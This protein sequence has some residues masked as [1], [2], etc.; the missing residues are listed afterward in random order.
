MGILRWLLFLFVGLPTQLVVM[1]V[2]PIL[3]LIWKIFFK[4]TN[5]PFRPVHEEIEA[6]H[7]KTRNGGMYLDNQDDHGAF[8][9]YGFIGKSGLNT[10]IDHKGNF[11]RRV[12]EDYTMNKQ[13]VSG[14]V[15]VAWVFA[16]MFTKTDTKTIK[17]AV[18]NYLAYLGTRSYDTAGKGHVSNRC[19]NF[20]INYCPDSAV[21]KLG[22]PMAGP[23]FYTTSALLARAYHIGPFYKLAFW[24]HWIILGGWYWALAPM[25]FTPNKPLYYVR[26]ITMKALYIHL[27]VFGPKWWI[28]KPMKFITFD[29]ATSENDLFRAMLGIEPGHLPMSMDA[30][31]SQ[32]ADSTSRLTEDMNFQIPSIIRLIARTSRAKEAKK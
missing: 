3:Y 28:I 25:L 14:D 29:I 16:S 12:N 18:N 24:L 26:D 11:A 22:Q 4:K 21:L 27:Q 1:L 10:L 23:Q 30:F 20:G 17:K 19:N 31:F 9:M 6:W 5:S 8:T 2:Y 32:E 15:V 13:R 7:P